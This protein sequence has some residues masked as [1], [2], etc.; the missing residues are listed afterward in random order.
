MGRGGKWS[1]EA[2][3][4]SCQ[5]PGRSGLFREAQRICSPRCAF[6]S[7]VMCVDFVI[8][9][10]VTSLTCHSLF[11]TLWHGSKS[12]LNLMVPTTTLSS[13]VVW[14]L[15]TFQFRGDLIGDCFLVS[16]IHCCWVPAG[17][18]G[19]NVPVIHTHL[20]FYFI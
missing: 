7:V 18:S 8:L 11:R 20:G 14:I 4:V 9:A 12:S 6:Y 13:K 19:Q 3:G 2:M 10:S 16:P 15:V 5:R 1:R 17:T